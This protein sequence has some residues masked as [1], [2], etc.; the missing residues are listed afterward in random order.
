M[1]MRK[2]NVPLD[3]VL[4]WQFFGYPA[5]AGKGVENWELYYLPKRSST[6]WW[7]F[8]LRCTERAAGKGNYWIGFG[9]EE[10]RLDRWPASRYLETGRPELHTDVLEVLNDIVDEGRLIDLNNIE[11]GQYRYIPRNPPELPATPNRVQGGSS[12]SADSG[13]AAVT[14]L[15]SPSPIS[16]EKGGSQGVTGAPEASDGVE[17]CTDSCND[18]S[19]EDLI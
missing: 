13:S 12:A 3:G 1:R 16:S 9:L 17:P 18:F 19:G 15:N 5:K 7:N 8:K 14:P 11:V 4:C 6:G 10:R 2:G